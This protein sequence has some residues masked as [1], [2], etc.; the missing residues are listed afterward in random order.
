MPQWVC[1]KDSKPSPA[2]RQG[3]DDQD[4]EEDD[5]T[6]PERFHHDY[7]SC[8]FQWRDGKEGHTDLDLKSR[9]TVG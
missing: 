1:E 7:P 8:A 5:S 4:N 9:E 6:E 3:A 2:H